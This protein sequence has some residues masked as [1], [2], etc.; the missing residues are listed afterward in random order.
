MQTV[1]LSVDVLIACNL[2]HGKDSMLRAGSPPDRPRHFGPGSLAG[3]ESSKRSP[4]EWRKDASDTSIMY[5]NDQGQTLEFERERF[6]ASAAA[7]GPKS[8]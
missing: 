6:V 1:S 8:R 7:A 2:T 4:R 3:R 5:M